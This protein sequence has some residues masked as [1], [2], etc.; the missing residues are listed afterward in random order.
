MKK[1]SMMPI[2][3][4]D[5]SVY[6]MSPIPLKQAVLPGSSPIRTWAF[7]PLTMQNRI[8]ETKTLSMIQIRLVYL[9][10]SAVLAI[11][12]RINITEIYLSAMTGHLNSLKRTDGVSS[13]HSREPGEYRKKI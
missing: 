5:C 8:P 12:T 9:H 3:Y 13:L 4:P 11:T 1:G 2:C 6:P 10:C 7:P